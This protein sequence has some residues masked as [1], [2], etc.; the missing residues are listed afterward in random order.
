MDNNVE[1][2]PNPWYEPKYKAG[3]IVA[4]ASYPNDMEHLLILC[5]DLDKDN[6]RVIYHVLTLE[7]GYR[8]KYDAQFWDNHPRGFVPIQS[9]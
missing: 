2:A 5:E 3:D 6:G 9:D 4:D 8:D 7:G 1:G